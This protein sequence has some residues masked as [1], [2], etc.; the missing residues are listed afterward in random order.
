MATEIFRNAVQAE[1]E[2][3][4][5]ASFPDVPAFYENAELPDEGSIGPIW[6][7]CLIRWYA[8]KFV[9]VGVNP[10]GR[11]TGTVVTNVYYRQAEGTA[12]PDNVIDSLKQR[13]RARRLGGGLL[14]MPQRTVPTEF[15]GWYKVGLMTPFSLDDA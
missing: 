7:D 4:R 12:V 5:L 8:A 2:A 11:H 10:L 3:W 15:S 1:V 9:S 14:L 13:L 6:I